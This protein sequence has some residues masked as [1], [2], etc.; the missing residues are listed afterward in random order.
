MCKFDLKSDVE[1]QTSKGVFVKL[2]DLTPQF[3]LFFS[4]W[5]INH[6]TH[7]VGGPVPPTGWNGPY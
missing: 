7:L 5:C 4:I 3:T 2:T 1:V 6:F